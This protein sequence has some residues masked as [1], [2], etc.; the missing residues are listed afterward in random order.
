[1]TDTGFSS[2]ILH[3]SLGW[4]SIQLVYTEDAKTGV[5]QSVCPLRQII[6]KKINFLPGAKMAI[7][8]IPDLNGNSLWG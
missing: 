7:S 3:L 4:F 8:Y 1:M 6:K 2:Q 5:L